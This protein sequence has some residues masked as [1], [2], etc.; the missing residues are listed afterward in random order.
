MPMFY[1]S[2]V[3]SLRIRFDKYFNI[4][5]ERILQ[6][7]DSVEDLILQPEAE[8][9]KILEP[10]VTAETQSKDSFS[11]LV[12]V[13]PASASV[14]IPGYRQAGKFNLSFKWKEL[15]IDPR[16]IRACGVEIHLGSVEPMDFATGMVKK[17]PNWT[18]K[19]MINIRDSLDIIRKDTVVMVGTVDSWSVDYDDTGGTVNLEGRDIRGLLLDMKTGPEIFQNIDTGQDIKSV[20]EQVLASHPLLGP[21]NAANGALR[22]KVEADP[23]LFP[24][25]KLPLVLED[26][27]TTRVNKK[28]RVAARKGKIS[29]TTKTT[30]SQPKSTPAPK[31]G[32]QPAGDKDRLGY[33]DVI[34]HYCYLVG[35]IPIVV[36]ETIVLK[37]VRNVYNTRVNAGT[38]T[39]EPTV[40]QDGLPRVVVLS[41]GRQ[42]ELRFRRLVYGRDVKSL[43]FERKIGGV[44][45]QPIKLVSV[46]T[47]SDQRGEGR[48]ISVFHP[49]ESDP[50]NRKTTGESADGSAST[51][52]PMIIH[53]TGVKDKARLAEIAEAIYEEI[54]H[55][56]I[57]GSCQ[58]KSL[59]SFGG[60]NSDPDLL[61]LRPGDPIQFLTDTR[62]L[63]SRA[64][65]VSE[66]TDFARMDFDQAVTKTA[67]RL[68]NSPGDLQMARAI[69]AASRGM[70]FELS[71]F[72]RVHTVKYDWKPDSG[73]DISFDFHNFIEVRSQDKDTE[74]DPVASNPKAPVK[75]TKK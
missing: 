17:E 39:K 7:F 47:S 33:W 25:G 34:I 29:T 58:T 49:P 41:D 55:S 22:V 24:F 56:E 15:P 64:P 5:P 38:N 35:V 74:K 10:L 27:L 72:F 3:V 12:Y 37:P 69:V 21:A 51:G 42:E 43:K 59:C 65:L 16:L 23:S 75:S 70:V 44:K 73:V 66:L 8:V 46:D 53:M 48:M 6:S 63:S 13:M 9:K 36:G 2:L 45:A 20:V 54:G 32:G 26:D 30:T 14:E 67:E 50:E 1:P 40:F 68:G 11:H 57:G 62:T 71:S 19:S 18:R 61:R 60:D 28:A 31:N 52:T 4:V